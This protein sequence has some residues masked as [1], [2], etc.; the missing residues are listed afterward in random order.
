MVAF[1]RIAVITLRRRPDRLAAFRQRLGA[2][3][4]DGLSRLEVVDA[5][6]G[7]VCPKPDWFTGPP[8]AWGCYRSHH[9]LIED[10]L[11]AGHQAVLVF[12]D[13]ATFVPDFPDRLEAF[14]GLLP[15]DWG[16]GYLGGQHLRKPLP[17][18][19]GLFRGVNINRTHAYAV[20][21]GEQMA[22]VYRFLHGGHHWRGRHHVDHHYGRLQGRQF[23]AYAPAEWL[24]GQAEGKSDI[25]GNVEAARW[26]SR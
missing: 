21:G 20:R 19:G 8:G 9:R 24:C 6:D 14:L 18:E 25:Q 13:D 2:A 22:E 17:A 5:I 10:S 26:W 4:P 15:A 11:Q 16:L 23:P 1:D 12:E 3:W 7:A